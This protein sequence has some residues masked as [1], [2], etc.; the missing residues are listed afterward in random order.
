[1]STRGSMESSTGPFRVHGHPSYKGTPVAST[2]RA[3][4]LGLA[5]IFIRLAAACH[6]SAKGERAAFGGWWAGLPSL[7][8][9]FRSVYHAIS[10]R[11][12]AICVR[13]SVQRPQELRIAAALG[14]T[15]PMR[16]P[17]GSRMITA[18][19]RWRS[20]S[21]RCTIGKEERA[22]RS[23]FGTC[24]SWISGSPGQANCPAAHPAGLESRSDG[25]TRASIGSRVSREEKAATAA[26]F[27]QEPIIPSRAARAEFL[28]APA[29]S[30]TDHSAQ[31][32]DPQCLVIRRD[33]GQ[34]SV[35][36]AHQHRDGT[37][38]VAYRANP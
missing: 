37:G 7:R 6:T 15:G 36:V 22:L 28:Y 23:R 26:Q 18:R 34:G 32:R 5:A 30:R 24:G 21:M 25:A 12:V 13:A 4:V 10:R 11:M 3:D 8:A 16:C 2:A 33:P 31:R 29:A 27:Q 35:G 9:S 20:S 19:V 17:G 38:A 14:R 1:M